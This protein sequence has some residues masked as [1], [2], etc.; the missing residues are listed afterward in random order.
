[1]DFPSNS[2]QPRPAPNEQT[3]Q[4][5]ENKV[6]AV[7]DGVIRKKSLGKRFVESFFSG[8]TPK[9]VLGYVA[10]EVLI[11]AAKDM[12]R[13]AGQEALDR[14]LY[15]NGG[16]GSSS[17]H[18]RNSPYVS[19]DRYASSKTT[20]RRDDPRDRLGPSSRA[21]AMHD[22]DEVVLSTRAEANEVIDR[23][24]ERLKRYELVTVAEFYQFTNN[25][26]TP[27]DENWGWTD[28]RGVEPKKVRDGFIVDLPRPEHLK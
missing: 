21:R 25:S 11:P 9:S 14:I 4:I 19:Y 10:M 8:E 23:M 18:S 26:S 20:V 3:P 22:F 24:F 28:L 16:G 6:E 17:R 5:E 27:P 7:A 15:R 12:I 1:M 13:D 2:K